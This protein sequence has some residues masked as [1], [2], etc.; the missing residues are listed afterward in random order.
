MLSAM[1]EQLTEVAGW[2]GV[3][4]ILGGYGALSFGYVDA[5]S[6]WYH[7]INLIGGVGIIIDAVADKNYQP[8]VLNVVWIAFAMFAIF[9]IM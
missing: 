5:T 6:L 4:C 7:G 1:Q 3:I 8:A 9:R 2:I